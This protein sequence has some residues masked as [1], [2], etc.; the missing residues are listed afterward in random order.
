M[1]DTLRSSETRQVYVP[2]LNVLFFSQLAPPTGKNLD[3]LPLHDM[4]VNRAA[5]IDG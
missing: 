4:D 5:N 1:H 2:Y 3:L